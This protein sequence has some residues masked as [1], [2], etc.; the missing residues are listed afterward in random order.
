MRRIILAIILFFVTASG[1]RAQESVGVCV[2]KT[3]TTGQKHYREVEKPKFRG[4]P[5]DDF[6]TWVVKN[7]IYPENAKMKGIQGRVLTQFVIDTDGTVTD[8]KILRGYDEELN[9]EALRV[10]SSSPKW[11]PATVDGEP[12]KCS[13]TF[14]V[15]FQ[16]N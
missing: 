15:V 9:R 3:D 16:L 11:E 7:L 1:L 13:F 2:I 6:S 8:L 12:M 14:P 4:G 10:I 5:A